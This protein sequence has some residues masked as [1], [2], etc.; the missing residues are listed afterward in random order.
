MR[1][2]SPKGIASPG[3]AISSRSAVGEGGAGDSLRWREFAVLDEPGIIPAARMSA[4]PID[5]CLHRSP[6]EFSGT[7]RSPLLAARISIS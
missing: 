4:K 5:F 2:E 7:R 6:E 3:F 1:S